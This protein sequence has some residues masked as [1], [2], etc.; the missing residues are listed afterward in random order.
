MESHLLDQPAR[1]Q[2]LRLLRDQGYIS[3]DA[4]FKGM[5]A[6]RSTRDWAQW[7]T[8]FS[9]I[10]GSALLL[11]GII[12]F[13][14]YNW[15]GLHRLAKLGLLQGTVLLSWLAAIWIGLRRLTGQMCLLGACVLIGVCF[16]VYGQV[17]QTGADAFGFFMA[18]SISI[19][20]WVVAGRF[21]PLWVLWLTLVNLTVWLFWDQVGQFRETLAFPYLAL[22]M[23]GV[24]GLALGLSETW[25]RC[26][27][28]LQQRW[29]RPLLLL[30]TLTALTSPA[31]VWICDF[32][33]CTSSAYPITSFI[34]VI[35]T[36]YLFVHYNFRKFE[37]TQL[38]LILMDVELVALFA[39][40]RLLFEGMDRDPT[41]IFFLIALAT[42]GMSTG[43]LCYIRKRIREQKNHLEVS[44]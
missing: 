41:G 29:L 38:S 8:V 21:A 6:L 10:L 36:G 3:S 1:P 24:N 40:T 27:D 15:E 34:W 11:A 42:I 17:Y 26:R 28:W 32:N 18:W 13:F 23:V 19:L 25:G 9:L 14:A 39:L 7:T 16:A 37:A 20:P 31:L 22:A 12:F 33:D 35:L 43:V 2:S 44:V 30:A 5:Q 4:Y